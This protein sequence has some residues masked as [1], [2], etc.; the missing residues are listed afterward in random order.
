ME[1]PRLWETSGD[2]AWEQEVKWADLDESNYDDVPTGEAEEEFVRQLVEL[3]LTNVLSA[4]QVC[5]LALWASKASAAR[6]RC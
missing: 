4:K 3:K 5:T 1:Q 6:T 2:V